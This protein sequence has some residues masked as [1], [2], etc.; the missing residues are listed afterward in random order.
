MPPT[1]YC[2]MLFSGPLCTR[3][4]T[5]EVGEGRSEACFSCDRPT[6]LLRFFPV[7]SSFPGHS[8]DLDSDAH[9]LSCC[10][11]SC[12][13]QFS[14]YEIHNVVPAS[15]TFVFIKMSSAT[16]TEQFI[17]CCGG[18]L[19]RKEKTL[20]HKTCALEHLERSRRRRIVDVADEE[21]RIVDVADEDGSWTWPTKIVDVADEDKIV[22][23]NEDCHFLLIQI[24]NSRVL[25]R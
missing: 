15:A 7:P 23:E 18:H 17:P 10:C 22:D 12:E 2:Q 8:S 25:E 6:S 14:E 19:V 20:P 9:F 11:S 1:T 4:K 3:D 5:C 21:R 13:R 16:W 24:A